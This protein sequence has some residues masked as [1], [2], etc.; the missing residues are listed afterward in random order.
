MSLFLFS[1]S[2][3]PHVDFAGEQ[4]AFHRPGELA[5]A[6]TVASSGG[7]V[8]RWRWAASETK[9]RLAGRQ[10]VPCVRLPRRGRV[11]LSRSTAP[12]NGRHLGRWRGLA[13]K[14]HAVP[15]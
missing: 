13:M 10:F 6:G 9:K 5:A 7:P 2:T 3:F 8:E 15:S 12:A 1:R 14:R 4:I 11:L